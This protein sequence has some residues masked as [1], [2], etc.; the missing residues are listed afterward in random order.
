M[1]VLAQHMYFLYIYKPD[2]CLHMNNAA[3][4][5]TLFGEVIALIALL[6]ELSLKGSLVSSLSYERVPVDIG[7][8]VI[9]T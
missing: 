8:A 1:V 2:Q 4:A 3:A 5:E 6:L 9:P 7:R